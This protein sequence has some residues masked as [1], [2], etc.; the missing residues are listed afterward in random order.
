M[1][2]FQALDVAWNPYF[3]WLAGNNFEYLSVKN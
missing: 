2:G 3:M 1:F